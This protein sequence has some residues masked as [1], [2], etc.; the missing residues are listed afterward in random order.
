ME[1]VTNCAQ[2]M[3]RIRRLVVDK[4]H[5]TKRSY[6]FIG[7]FARRTW[8]RLSTRPVLD[9]TLDGHHRISSLDE[10][11]AL[12]KMPVNFGSIN[13][14]RKIKS[15]INNKSIKFAWFRRDLR[16]FGRYSMSYNHEKLNFFSY[17]L[18]LMLETS[19]MKNFR[20]V[21]Y[22]TVKFLEKAADS[23]WLPGSNLLKCLPS[24]VVRR[25]PSTHKQI[26][27]W[28]TLTFWLYK[29]FSSSIEFTWAYITPKRCFL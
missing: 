14:V 26:L 11:Q 3:V 10:K 6:F 25:T 21:F 20:V 23:H 27:L 16:H 17:Y 4:K 1:N 9:L 2:H 8:N 28:L 15:I 12:E 13:L 5:R 18:I 19:T 7:Y 24:P 29:L 22:C